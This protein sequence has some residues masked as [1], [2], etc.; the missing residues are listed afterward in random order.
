MRG[1]VHLAV[2][3]WKLLVSH[4]NI[5]REGEFGRELRERGI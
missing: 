2:I 1:L 5:Q 3:N 4:I